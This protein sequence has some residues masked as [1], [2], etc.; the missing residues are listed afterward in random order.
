MIAF[1][2]TPAHRALFELLARVSLRV[3]ATSAE[4][5]AA[6]I[7]PLEPSRRSA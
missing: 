2:P 6:G 7:V 4:H 5:R 3:Q 1:T